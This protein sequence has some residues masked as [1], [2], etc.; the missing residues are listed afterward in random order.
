MDIWA[1]LQNDDYL[2]SRVLGF[3]YG[4]AAH[5]LR[6]NGLVNDSQTPN[7]FRHMSVN[8]KSAR[9]YIVRFWAITCLVGE[10]PSSTACTRHVPILG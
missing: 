3:V 10:R 1:T 8:E 2:A 6:T 7:K 4:L 5:T 9:H